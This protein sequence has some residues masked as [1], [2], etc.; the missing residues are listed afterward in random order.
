[1]IHS[2]PFPQESGPRSKSDKSVALGTE[3]T[4]T[5]F[6]YFGSAP[7]SQTPLSSAP[8]WA[9]FPEAVLVKPSDKPWKPPRPV[10]LFFDSLSVSVGRSVCLSVCVCLSLLHSNCHLEKRL[11]WKSFIINLAHAAGQNSLNSS[12]G[13]QGL[14]SLKVFF[15]LILLLFGLQNPSD[16]SAL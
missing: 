1:M 5:S 6:L 10:R 14:W 3:E 2:P 11:G 7:F 8:V 4:G 16:F 15:R 13:C 9:S 12:R